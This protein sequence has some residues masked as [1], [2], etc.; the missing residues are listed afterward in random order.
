MF[1][2]NNNYIAGLFDGEGWIMITRQE[3][4]IKFGQKTIHYNFRIG[5]EMTSYDILNKICKI[6]GGHI[7]TR[8]NKRA[9]NRKITHT[10]YRDG[11]NAMNFLKS[12]KDCLFIKRKQANIAIKYQEH[13]NKFKTKNLD[14]RR[15]SIPKKEI[16]YREKMVQK[17]RNLNSFNSLRK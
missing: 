14:F 8:P 11:E 3:P 7:Y 16:N 4:S 5:I 10:W 9:I 13:I 15:K 12:I 6:Y 2:L 1:K 17:I